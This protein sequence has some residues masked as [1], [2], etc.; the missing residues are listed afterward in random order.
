MPG[1]TRNKM[2][3]LQEL[4]NLINTINEETKQTLRKQKE[5]QIQLKELLEYQ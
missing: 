3:R 2:G 5:D 4:M 1:I